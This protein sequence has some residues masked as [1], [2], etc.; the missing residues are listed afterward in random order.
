VADEHQ[1]LFAGYT[2]DRGRGTLLVD[3]KPLHLRPQAYELLSYMAAQ[4]GRLVSKDELISHVWHGRAVGDDSLVQCLRDVRTALGPQGASAIRTVRGRGYI[5]EPPAVPASAAPPA[6]PV[7][8]GSEP[9]PAPPSFLPRRLGLLLL[10][11][12]L[13]ALAVVGYRYLQKTRN[14]PDEPGQSLG[15]GYR[16]DGDAQL[17]YLRARH[18]HRLATEPEVLTAIGLY[19]QAIAVD[20][21]HALAH[22]GLAEAWRVLAIVGQVPSKDAFPQ[23]K[24]AA[25]RA[26]ALDEGLVEAHVALGWIG[27]SFDRDW[28][29][30]ERELKRAIELDPASTDAHRA[31]AHL[32]SNMGRHEEAILEIARAREKDPRGL[33]VRTLE[34]QFL[35]YAGRYDDA[36]D[37]LRRTLEMDPDFWPAH[38]GLGRVLL[39][40]DQRPAAIEA[41]RKARELSG[42]A[43]EPTT[44]LAY[45][46]AASGA[47]NEAVGLLHELENRSTTGYVPFYSFAMIANGL[48]D[49]ERALLELDRSVEAREVQA[50]FIKIDTRWNWLRADLRF[51]ALMRRI[52]LK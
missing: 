7:T 39:L 15:S 24:A 21:R 12:W 25:D 40:R 20:A 28:A 18:H 51:D 37:R 35:F 8:L 48:R 34:A 1:R 13:L 29:G 27:F 6:E 9:T 44:Q 46:L 17:L 4:P 16:P 26:L 45:A 42:G 3:G 38:Q 10:I 2:L 22:A 32:L 5:F 23:A 50:T 52:G 31:Y 33:L 43:P 19:E 41:F 11:G 49:R 47:S 14:T 30:A 36:E